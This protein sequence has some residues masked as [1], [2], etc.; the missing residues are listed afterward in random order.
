MPI[1]GLVALDDGQM[2]ED[3]PLM[4]V[5]EQGRHAP[6][7][8]YL[9]ARFGLMWQHARDAFDE[10]ETHHAMYD[11]DQYSA[12]VMRSLVQQGLPAPVINIV[13]KALDNMSGRERAQRLKPELLPR[14]AGSKILA[15]GYARLLEY[16]REA[17]KAPWKFSDAFESMLK[18]PGAWTSVTVDDTDPTKT[19]HRVDT[20]PFELML[21]DPAWRS[22]DVEDAADLCQL[23]ATRLAWAVEK[24]PQHADLLRSQMGRE[25]EANSPAMY[26]ATTGGDYNNIP[27]LQTTTWAPWGAAGLGPMSKGWCEPGAGMILLRLHWWWTYEVATFAILPDST[28]FELRRDDPELMAAFQMAMAQGAVLREGQVRQYHWALC[29]GPLVLDHGPSP[30]W[31][32]RFPYV[33]WEAFRDRYG[34]PYGIVRRMVW[35][36]REVNTAH[37]RKNESARSRWAIVRKGSMTP[38][39]YQQLQLSLGRSNF[40]VQVNSTG[41]LRIDSD[42]QDAVMW[43]NFEEQAIAYVDE[44]AGLN[45]AA[46]GDRSN[47]KSGEAIKAR[48][49]QASQ[50]QGKL[51]DNAQRAQQRSYELMLSNI[52]QVTTREKAQR[53][54]GLRNQ[55]T[56]FNQVDVMQFGAALGAS[57]L[58]ALGFDLIISDQVESATQQQQAREDN[59]RLI[60][61]LP[62]QLRA[63]AIPM[64]LR[65]EGFAGAE[66]LEQLATWWLQSQ[67]MLPPQLGGVPMQPQPVPGMAPEQV[68]TNS[69]QM[70]AQPPMPVPMLAQAPPMEATSQPMPQDATAVPVP[71]ETV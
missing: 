30:Y 59:E 46:Y 48:A 67:G 27:G 56:P 58:T 38:Y 3:E 32:R 50:N 63:M 39:E 7:G 51:F 54:V 2:P 29:V 10:A 66:Q 31:H 36:Q 68:G 57:V 71:A 11:G 44:V 14:H 5:D 9:L 8:E 25:L 40:V 65:E 12:F 28:A 18:G 64:L 43:A 4:M 1:G 34:Q 45:E 15:D 70:N 41:D 24:Y 22:S 49:A 21:V 35:P 19:P 55:G 6:M 37:L 16:E 52:V 47:E 20:I 60:G 26:G 23:V 17:T 33:W 42:K 62:D 69:A 61:L 13:A 53:V